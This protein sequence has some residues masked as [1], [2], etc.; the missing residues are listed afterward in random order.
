M[1]RIPDVNLK[2][3]TAD[4]KDECPSKFFI[5]GPDGRDQLPDQY[6]YPVGD[7]TDTKVILLCEHYHFPYVDP[8]PHTNTSSVSFDLIPESQ[9][10]PELLNAGILSIATDVLSAR[11]PDGMLVQISY[12]MNETLDVNVLRIFIHA[13]VMG[14][15]SDHV[16]LEKI[17]ADG[18]EKQV[19]TDVDLFGINESTH[20]YNQTVRIREGD[21]VRLACTFIGANE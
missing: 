1:T 14:L 11:T 16:I 3:W 6:A 7:G 21:V 10:D 18:K 5:K 8:L 4:F 19:I 2:G 15:K 17:S 20:L 13:H 9:A 12:V